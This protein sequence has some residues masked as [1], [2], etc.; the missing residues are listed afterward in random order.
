MSRKESK[1]AFESK[2]SKFFIIQMKHLLGKLGQNLFVKILL[3]I[4][5]NRVTN[6]E[7]SLLNLL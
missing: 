3:Q 6:L 4:A 5:Y 7:S 1:Y 2:L